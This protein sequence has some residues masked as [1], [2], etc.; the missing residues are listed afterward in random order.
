MI[1]R[2]TAT[3]RMAAGRFTPFLLADW[4][5]DDR[6]LVEGFFAGDDLGAEVAAFE[7]ACRARSDGVVRAVDSGRAAIRIALD[8]LDL[9]PGDEVALPS[10]SCYGVVAPVVAAGLAPVLVDIDD[11]FNISA[12]S[13]VSAASSRLRAVVLPHFGGLPAPDAATIATWARAREIAIIE[14]AAQAFG[15]PA[16]GRLGDVV[17]YSTGIGKPLFGPGGGWVVARRADLSLRLAGRA[18][19]RPT[20]SS[21]DGRVRRFVNAFGDR[22]MRRGWRVLADAVNARTGVMAASPEADWSEPTGMSGI[23]AALARRQMA[24]ID[25]NVE[26]QRRWLAYWRDRLAKANLTSLHLPPDDTIALKA[27]ASFD[28]PTAAPDADRLKRTLLAEGVEVESAYTPLHRR[29]PFDG[30]RR[31]SLETTDRR[32]RHVFML[33]TRPNL[34]ESDRRRFDRAVA[35]LTGR[36]RPRSGV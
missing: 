33:P 19:P 1:D 4:D 15:H 14:D 10:Y 7:E 2:V 28:G 30:V 11:T 35:T 23:E 24:R 16:I 13:V 22:L 34:D 3:L 36:P 12:A 9:Q 8:L 31:G 29:P 18:L 6:A 32:W 25:R 21:T 20:L 17:V 27:W 5:A 26:R